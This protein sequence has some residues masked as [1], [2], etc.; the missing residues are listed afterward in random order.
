M[1]FR[2]TVIWDDQRKE[3][4]KVVIYLYLRKENSQLFFNSQIIKI[5]LI[6]RRFN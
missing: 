2:S 5:E 1:T 4:K 6:L 3:W